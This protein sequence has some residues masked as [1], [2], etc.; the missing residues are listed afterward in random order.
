MELNLRDK[1]ALVTGAGRGIGRAL[2]LG[3]AGAGADVVLASRTAAQLREVAGEVERLGRRAHVLTC[4]LSQ[5]AETSR[6]AAEALR[7]AGQVD[8]LVNCAGTMVRVP[9]LEATEP[10]WERTFA[11]NVKGTFFLSQAVAGQMLERGSG[12]I[13]NIT[14]VA[15]EVK[16]RASTLYASAKAAVVQMTRALAV[17]LAPHVRVN[18]VGPA[19][20]ETDLNRDWLSQPD[21]AAYVL[22]NTPLG[23]VGTPADVVGAVV[24]LASPAAG[25][26]TGQ[27]L[28]VDGGWTAQ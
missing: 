21:N 28:L 24:F 27:H 15:A 20:V 1:V 6:A 13:I 26:I 19:Y 18:A 7:V 16:T 23:R 17:D 8:I 11:L 25:Y 4:D 2:A 12:S 10:D 14:S 5:V 22:A 3:L 9:T